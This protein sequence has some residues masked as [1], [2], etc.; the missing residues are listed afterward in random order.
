VGNDLVSDTILLMRALVFLSG[1][2]MVGRGKWGIFLNV[3]NVGIYQKN[4]PELRASLSASVEPES[5]SAEIL[6]SSLIFSHNEPC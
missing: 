6:N 2:P 3:G 4:L 1:L 5:T